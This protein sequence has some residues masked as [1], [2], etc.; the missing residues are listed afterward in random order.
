MG[1]IKV[2]F[3]CIHNSARSQM[4]EALLTEMGKDIF[5]AESAG[6]ENGALNPIAVEVMKES[7]IDISG[8][9]SKSVFDLYVQGNVYNY[10]ITVCDASASE[11]CPVFPGALTVKNWDIEDPSTFEGTHD[12]KLEKVRAVRDQIKERIGVFIEEVRNLAA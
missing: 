8:N 10:V 7:G 11:R 1:R 4:A 2:L 3:V 5:Q 6:I 9:K 12:Q